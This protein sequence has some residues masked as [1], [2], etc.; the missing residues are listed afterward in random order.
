[1]RGSCLCLAGSLSVCI[2]TVCTAR[3][4]ITVSPLAADIRLSASP[5]KMETI[6]RLP[7]AFEKQGDGSDGR[8]V[9]RSQ[10]YALR[11]EGGKAT[12]GVVTK[13][14]T[15]HA[16]SLEFAGARPSKAVPGGEL[17]GKVNYIHG[18]DP[19]KWRIGVPTYSRVTYPDTYPGI[20]VVYYGNQQQLEFDLVVKPGTN[21]RAIRMKVSGGKISLDGAGE[22]EDR[23]HRRCKFR[24][25]PAED[26]PGV[27]GDAQSYLR[28]LRSSRRG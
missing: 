16:I 2:L 18:N 22:L 26:L 23:G 10:G 14:K 20:D 11:L 21:P 1:M 15:R 8:F 4:Q 19:R 3:A 17:P 9:A 28:A 24:D 13:D 7:L 12:V 25:C 27:R 6:A 5:L